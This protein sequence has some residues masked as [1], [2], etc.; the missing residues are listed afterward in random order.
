M[1]S[2]QKRSALLSARGAVGVR[3][4]LWLALRRDRVL[5]PAWVFGLGGA[6]LLTSSSYAELYADAASRREVV[7]TLGTTPATLALYG[8]IYADSVGGLVAWRLGGIALALAGLMSILIV[9]RHTRAEEETGRA[10]LVGAGV[11]GRHA[12]LAA[13]LLAAAIASF[14]LGVVVVL[15]VLSAGL[16]FTGALA[17]GAGFTA[18][19]LVFGTVAAVTAQAV[20]S[21]RA[22]NGLAVAVLGAA[23]ALRAIGDAG[24]HWLAWL[25]PLGW[26]QAMRA[27]ADERWWLLAP[28]LALAALLVVAAVQLSGRRDL[29]AGIL[30]PRPGPARGTLTTPLALA[31]RLQR[32][33]LAGWAAGFAIIGA[34]FGSIAQDIGD[35]IGDSADVRDALARLG[36]SESLV[37]A[38]LAATFGIL[39]LIAAAYAVQAVLRLRGEEASGRA[40]PLLATAVSRTRWA[41][42]HGVIAL[43][44]TVVLLLVA[45]L[46]AGIAHAAQ[47]GDAGQFPRLLGAALAQVPAAWVLAG[48]ALL[49]FGLAPRAVVASWAALAICL[50]LA[51]LGPVVELSQ[52]VIDLSP[53]AHSPQLPGGDFTPAPLWLA[54]IAAALAAAGLAALRRRDITRLASVADAERVH[55]G[56]VDAGGVDV[57]D[58]CDRPAARRCGRRGATS[59]DADARRAAGRGVRVARERQAAAQRDVDAVA[60]RRGVEQVG[61]RIVAERAGKRELAGD[62][63]GLRVD[64]DDAVAGAVG[65]PQVAVVRDQRDAVRVG[66]HRGRPG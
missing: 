62:A 8:R 45:G 42:S 63:V 15:A 7:Q 56:A 24:P 52:S 23:F 53:F 41:L 25:S 49:L 36:G 33:A 10:E 50:A 22:A 20:S 48:V 59:I 58:A 4:L 5:I 34:A 38:Y 46:C 1:G 13:A 51:E 44:G 16:A 29:G 40:E 39:A 2:S 3:L 31:W 37:D 26:A 66:V 28:L 64:H 14:A 17:L 9:V 61:G 55:V 21:A 32:G 6:V 43:G 30:P 18:V 11:V 47:T 19:G 35:V 57:R 65:D 60:G 27:F 54:A 12:P